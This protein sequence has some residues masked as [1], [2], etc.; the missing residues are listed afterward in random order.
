LLATAS[1][2]EA[3]QLFTLC[4]QSQWNYQRAKRELADES[5]RT[6]ATPILYRPFDVRW[7]IWNS[8][9]AVHRRE[10]VN[11]HLLKSNIALLLPKQTKDSWG[12]LATSYVAAHKSASVYDPTSIIPLWI[13]Q[14]ANLLAGEISRMPNLDSNFLCA[15]HDN[16][17][18]VESTPEDIFAYLYAILY[19][20][21][22]RTRYA[23]FLR[24]DFPRVPIT[25]DPAL[26]KKLVE[27]GQQLIELHLLRRTLPAI[28]GYPKAGNNRVDK[29]EFRPDSDNPEKGRVQ[30]NAEQYFE[31]MPRPVWE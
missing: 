5:W 24:R 18:G 23:E 31:G 4:S 21:S 14:D 3:R 15:L 2:A 1:E 17:K 16:L 19:A 12:C 10:R 29:I 11:S 8:N 7:T 20:P 30:I 28:T 13:Y 9:I 27:L 26:F 22:Y 6:Q 25:S